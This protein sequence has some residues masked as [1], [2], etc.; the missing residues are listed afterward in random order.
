MTRHPRRALAR[1]A[2]LCC[3]LPMLAEARPL[4]VELF[5]SQGSSS[6]PPADVYLGALSGRPDVLALAFHVSYW[7]YLGWTDR[8]ALADSVERQKAY[9]RNLHRASVYTP[10]LVI[11]GRADALGLDRQ[12][13]GRALDQRR[14]EVPVFVSVRGA[15][16]RVEVGARAA[17]PPCDIVLVSYLRHAVS[18]ISHGE[19]AGRRLDEFNIVRELRTLGAWKGASASFR[20][21]VSLLPQD[22]TDIAVLVQSAHQGAILGA[23]ARAI[24]G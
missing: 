14:E 20:L 12:A 11:D 15:V 18:P 1:A 8:F 3:A 7:D 10:Q 17:T 4:V 24:R 16:V 2:L 13:I 22:A 9:A 5:T 6:C 21:P 23:A 19:N